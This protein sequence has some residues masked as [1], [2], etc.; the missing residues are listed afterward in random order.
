MPSNEPKIFVAQAPSTSRGFVV[1]VVFILI[2]A[3]VAGWFYVS[4][5][6]E[7]PPVTFIAT[8]VSTNGTPTVSRAV[9]VAPP[10]PVP[11]PHVEPTPVIAAADPRQMLAAID[12]HL[13]LYL[14]FTSSLDD[15]SKHRLKL[16]SSGSISVHDGC[17]HFPG[18]SFL[19]YP[20]IDLQDRP[21]AFAV[22]I[23]PMGKV[24]GYGILEQVDGGPGK[25]LH[26]LLRDID[27]PYIGF[28]MNDLRSPQS[29]MGDTGW[30]H[31]ALQFTGTHQQIW[32]N[33]LL[34]VERNAEAYHGSRGE[35]RIGKAPMWNNV[36][37]QC[38]KGAMRDLRLYDRA[39]TP[40][41][42]RLLAGLDAGEPE[43]KTKPKPLD[44]F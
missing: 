25:H 23:K 39:L 43:I 1:F 19:V 13:L 22:W 9:T 4:T 6:S 42:I 28:Y 12:D 31:L 16:E 15:H 26:L 27:K 35:T 33:G 14:P 21:F 5:E 11:A 44:T 36:P 20:H 17:T 2:I 7:Q 38:F 24:S 3:A 37:S 18:D 34:V 8:T 29:V 41:H 30:T 10:T 32:I 40:T